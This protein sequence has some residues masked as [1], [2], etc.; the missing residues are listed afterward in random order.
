MITVLLQILCSIMKLEFKYNINFKNRKL[1]LVK[2]S[3]QYIRIGVRMI[4]Q[5][6]NSKLET[7]LYT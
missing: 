4:A 2:L 6:S 7:V 3:L 1:Y 5:Y